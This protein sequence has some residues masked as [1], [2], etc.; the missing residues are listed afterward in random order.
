MTYLSSSVKTKVV[1]REVCP[2]INVPSDGFSWDM[3]ALRFEVL[4]T[5][6]AG[7]VF[8][9]EGEGWRG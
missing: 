8:F 9:S 1:K 6:G 4:A 2:R 7:A 3:I 5:S